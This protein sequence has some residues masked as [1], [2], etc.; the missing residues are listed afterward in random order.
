MATTTRSEDAGASTRVLVVDPSQTAAGF[1]ADALEFAEPTL[2]VEIAHDADE[3]IDRLEREAFD[4]VVS[5]YDL[6]GGD[7]LGL[8]E[9]AREVAPE[10]RGVLHTIEDD[11]RIAE[12][13]WE[14]GFAFAQKGHDIDRYDVIARHIVGTGED[15]EV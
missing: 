9:R 4:C 6:G 13:A 3:A 8:L 15:F 14:K 12:D 11:P 2:S 10:V 7:G 1:V 5:E